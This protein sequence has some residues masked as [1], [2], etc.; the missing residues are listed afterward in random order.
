MHIPD[1]Y[2]S[3][4]TCVVM[5]SSALP[6]WYVAVRRCRQRLS[7]RLIPLLSVFA[8]FSFVVMMLNIPLPGGTTAHVVGIGIA[9]IVLGPW[10]AII[11]ISVALFIQALFFGDGG[12]TT[13]GAN[14]F[15][16]AIAGSLV[17]YAAY[18]LI[19]GR[20]VAGSRRRIVASA[21]A[22][23]L[24]IN[25]SA[26][27]ASIEFGIQPMLFRDAT[28]APLYGVY[29]LSIAVPAIMIGHLTFGGLAELIVTAGIVAYLD[30]TFPGLLGAGDPS[31]THPL[32]VSADETKR[33]LGGATRRLW[34]IVGILL[35]LTPLGL[36]AAG[37]AW[38]EWSPS[39]FSDPAARVELAVVSRGQPALAE[40]PQ[41][42]VDLSRIWTAPMSH[43]APTFM[44]SA[45]FGYMLSAMTGCGL[46]LLVSL[47]ISAL[48]KPRQKYPSQKPESTSAEITLPAGPAAQ[49]TS[50]ARTGRRKRARGFVER[51]ADGLLHAFEYSLAAES[52]QN[53]EGLLQRLDPRIKLI[54]L[55]S[56]IVATAM[57]RNIATIAGLMIVALVAAALSRIP[58]RTLGA[59]IWIAAFV[60]SGLIALPAIFV[61]EGRAIARV[62]LLGWPV[63]AQGITAAV[64]L[65]SRVETAATIAMLLVLS[66]SWPHV[67]KALRVL[68]VPALVVVVLSMSYR[69]SFLMLRTAHEMFESRRS[70]MVGLLEGA[71]RRRL[72]ASSAGVLLARTVGLGN[73]VYLAMISRGFQGEAYTLDDFEIRRRDWVALIAFAVIAGLGFWFGRRG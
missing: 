51:T 1:G 73:E 50:L 18:R 31:G 28:G 39:D 48:V 14:C 71:E 30:R 9:A 49:T 7:A 61:S 3:P 65:L 58:I 12:I 47:S 24:A 42:L 72:V 21:I 41:S 10:G 26:L 43:Y 44:R 52:L 6:F 62:P 11:A 67:L 46:I 55:F 45:V 37:S 23:Y 5:Y 17:S 68:G 63:I 34:V 2:L 15:N 40:G 33:R 4:S 56:L 13:F 27:L 69:F 20:A 70:R 8:A 53:K 57:A 66:T 38:G 16:M 25:A 59:R 36:L 64:Y 60:F 54:G 19:A 29:P 22:G 32:D 35:I